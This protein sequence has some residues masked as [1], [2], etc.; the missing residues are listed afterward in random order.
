[1]EPPL[2][3]QRKALLDDGSDESGDEGGVNLAEGQEFKINEEYARRFE[4]NKKREELQRCAHSP[5]QLPLP[6]ILTAWFC[7]GGQIG[8]EIRLWEVER[9]WRR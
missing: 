4:H 2:K 1:M 6:C 5:N 3:K 7:S 9:G 8:Q